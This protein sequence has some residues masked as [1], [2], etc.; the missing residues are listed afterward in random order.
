MSEDVKPISV[1]GTSPSEETIYNGDYPLQR[2]FLFLIK[3]TP[4]GEV[5]KFY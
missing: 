3:G 5:K 2:P 1:N 4:T